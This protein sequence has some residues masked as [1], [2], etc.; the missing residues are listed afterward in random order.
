MKLQGKTALVTG[1]ASGIGQQAAFGL[2]R[3]GAAVM[4]TDVNDVGG[5]AT[6][7]AIERDG[8][9]AR[10]L[11]QDVRAEDGWVDVVA[12]TVAAFGSLDILVNNAGIGLGMRIED[13]ALD[14]W[15]RQLAINLTGVFLGCKHAIPVMRKAG[16]GSIVNISSVA[17][18]EGAVGLGAYS[19][20]KGGVRLLT[21]S[22]AKEYAADGIRCNSVH[23]GIID[24]PIWEAIGEDGGF[25]VP[26]PGL[27]AAKPGANRNEA[28][29]MIAT[30]APMQRAG[31]PAEV[32][33]GIV[34]LASPAS[35]F[36]TGSEL[37]IDGGLS[38]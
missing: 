26:I 30:A 21:K 13:M 14:D 27:D 10:Y 15:N 17:G 34:F 37:V 6:V 24:T 18:L 38:C 29:A 19:A 35:S 16:G 12:Q 36:I 9:R 1:G 11:H 33:D 22:I 32:A 4:V 7:A 8:G 3:E 31:T 2:A 28:V 25:P 5:A 20:T 23:P